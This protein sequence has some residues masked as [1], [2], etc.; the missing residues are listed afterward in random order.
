MPPPRADDEAP[1][2]DLTND[3][4]RNNDVPPGGSSRSSSTHRAGYAPPTNEKDVDRRASTAS[5]GAKLMNPLIGYT[6]QD[7]LADVD[8][9]VDARG[10]SEHREV[11]YQGALVAQ[12]SNQ[13]GAFEHIDI[14]SDSDKEVLRREVTHRWSQPFMLYFLCTLCAGSR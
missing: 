4:P 12:V 9:F 13:D 8:A 10:L 3:H 1:H 14:V 7:L 11:F 2:T 6:R 5:L